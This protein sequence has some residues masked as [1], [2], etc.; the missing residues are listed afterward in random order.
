MWSEI[1]ADIKKNNKHELSLHH[2][3]LISL[4][5]SSNG[6]VDDELFTLNH[7]NFIRL[8]NS[9]MPL[10]FSDDKFSELSNLQQLHLYGNQITSLPGK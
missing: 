10:K 1:F 6:K 5:E 2:G 8:T 4:L 3:E 9:H 7:L